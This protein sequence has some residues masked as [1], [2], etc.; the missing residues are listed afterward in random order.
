[1]EGVGANLAENMHQKND[2]QKGFNML[3]P[4]LFFYFSKNDDLK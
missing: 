1:M 4:N 3:V 2:P